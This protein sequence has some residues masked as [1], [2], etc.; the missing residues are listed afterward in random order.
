MSSMNYEC[1]LIYGVRVLIELGMTDLS[2]HFAI[3][4][5]GVGVMSFK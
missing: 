4:L 2:Q 3:N 1:L 5:S